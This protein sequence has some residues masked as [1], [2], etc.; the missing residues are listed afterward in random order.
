VSVDQPS[1]AAVVPA[2]PALWPIVGADPNLDPSIWILG[3]QW[4]N[5]SP[6]PVDVEVDYF[7]AES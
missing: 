6:T 1:P 2:R 4:S 5:F 7:V 3:D